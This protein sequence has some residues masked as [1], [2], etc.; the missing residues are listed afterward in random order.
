MFNT[1]G[2]L[3]LTLGSEVGCNYDVDLGPH[4]YDRGSIRVI[5][6]ASETW[7]EIVQDDEIQ[8][9][10]G[11][12]VSSANAEQTKELLRTNG[13]FEA[14]ALA[15]QI[16]IDEVVRTDAYVVPSS[17]VPLFPSEGEKQPQVRFFVFYGKNESFLGGFGTYGKQVFEC[18]PAGR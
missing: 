13:A 15:A 8:D 3:L 18:D 1:L 2:V 12:M 9:F 7:L 6:N 11:V 14:E 17:T 4:S 10:K 16:A 5:K